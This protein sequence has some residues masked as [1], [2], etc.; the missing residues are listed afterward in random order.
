[1]NVPEAVAPAVAGLA[2]ALATSVLIVAT[3]RWHGEFGTDSRSGPH[4]YHDAPVPRVGG[5]AVYAGLLAAAAVAG[6]PVRELLGLLCAGSLAALAA[7]LAEDVTNRIPPV[8][9][10]A[11]AM[12][13][14][15]SFCLLSGYAVTRLDLP[16]A[17]AFLALPPVSIAF[18]IVVLGGFAHAVN[19]IDGL[20]G[21]AA[22]TGIIMLCA[23]G[24]LAHLAGD[25]ALVWTAVASAAVLSGF[26]VVNFPSGRIFLGD[27]GAYLGGVMVGAVAVM[28]AARNPG[29]SAWM[30]AVVLAYPVLETL[31]SI[32]RKAAHRG[33]SPFRP[34]GMHLHQMVY[35]RLAARYGRGRGGGPA[36]PLAGALMWGGALTGL[37]FVVAFPHTRESAVLFLALQSTL[38][39]AVY[40]LLLSSN[41]GRTPDASLLPQGIGSMRGARASGV[42]ASGSGRVR[43]GDAD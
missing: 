35:R 22:G 29:V 24:S 12:L 17:D 40:R 32:A 27:G 3:R 1:M 39:V 37:V 21:L 38:Y 28:L 8:P 18:T 23:L 20:H 16:P 26:L 15:L 14:A 9:R 10:L 41:R 42:D 36:N 7:G 19:I 31:F 5:I 33:H 30:V 2:V 11:A 4:K 25:A 13:S 6:P 43:G 34:D